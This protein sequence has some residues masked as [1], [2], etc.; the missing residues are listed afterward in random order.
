M[1]DDPTLPFSQI[2]TSVNVGYSPSAAHQNTAVQY[3]PTG[4]RRSSSLQEVHDGYRVT[5][6]PDLQGFQPIENSQCLQGLQ[7][8]YGR[9]INDDPIAHQ[10]LPTAEHAPVAQKTSTATG[11]L[12]SHPQ[13]IPTSETTLPSAA[14]FQLCYQEEVSNPQEWFPGQ[15]ACDP[16]LENQPMVLDRTATNESEADPF[17]SGLE[18]I[19][20]EGFE[21]MSDSDYESLLRMLS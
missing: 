16:D 12:E 5:L 4:D 15:P 18:A 2:Q 9:N 14:A 17:L 13:P 6:Q 11:L 19:T 20:T 10:V 8:L 7:N 21:Q 3:F 1:L